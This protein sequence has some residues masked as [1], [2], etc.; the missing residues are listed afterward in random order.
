M[1]VTGKERKFHEPKKLKEKLVWGTKENQSQ[2]NIKG[3]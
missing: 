1:P 3:T 2:M